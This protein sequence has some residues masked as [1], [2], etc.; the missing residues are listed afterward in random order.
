MGRE[1][2]TQNVWDNHRWS[3]W[4]SLNKNGCRDGNA[5]P[6]L[7]TRIIGDLPFDFDLLTTYHRKAGDKEI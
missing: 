6:K 2:Y 7:H 4:L 5:A 3:D 1:K